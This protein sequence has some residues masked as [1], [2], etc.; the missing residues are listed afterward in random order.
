MV[1][2]YTQEE[3]EA[4]IACPKVIVQPLAKK[5]DGKPKHRQNEME[6]RSAD[7][8]YEYKVFLRQNVEFEENFSIGVRGREKGKPWMTLLRVNGPHGPNKEIRHHE[9]PHVHYHDFDNFTGDPALAIPVEDYFSLN[10]AIVYFF[11]KINLPISS[12]YFGGL[13]ART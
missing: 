3:I 5:W 1:A 4:M 7:G 10:E 2:H 12:D 13:F 11:K 6:L 9:K 8:K